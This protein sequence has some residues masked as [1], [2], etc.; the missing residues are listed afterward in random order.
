MRC[1]GWRERATGAPR[2]RHRHECLRIDDLQPDRNVLAVDLD[3]VLAA[4]GPRVDESLW[5]V[6]DIWAIGKTSF[7]IEVLTDADAIAGADLRQLADRAQQ[8]VDGAFSGYDP[9][10]GDPWGRAGCRQLV[11]RGPFGS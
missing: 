9:G 2:R 11:L 8:V 3:N 10:A 7:A 1:N 4:L 6:R 5:R